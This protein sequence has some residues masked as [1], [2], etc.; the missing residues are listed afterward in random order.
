MTY[1]ELLSE[2]E[3]FGEFYANTFSDWATYILVS[4]KNIVL[5]N[6]DPDDVIIRSTKRQKT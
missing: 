6:M 4:E 5:Q 1:H 2:E 3:F